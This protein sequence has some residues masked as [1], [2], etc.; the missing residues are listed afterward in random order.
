MCSLK[1]RNKPRK[2]KTKTT[3]NRR[4]KKVTKGI[5]KKNGEGRFQE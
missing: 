3:R 1:V 5:F 2:M 4:N